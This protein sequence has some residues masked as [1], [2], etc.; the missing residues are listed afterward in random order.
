MSACACPACSQETSRVATRC[1]ACGAFLGSP[2]DLINLSTFAAAAAGLVAIVVAV[3]VIGPNFGLS[4]AIAA[5]R[6]GHADDVQAIQE[7]SEQGEISARAPDLGWDTDRF[8]DVYLISFTYV[9]AKAENPKRYAAW[10]VYEPAT[11][12]TTKIQKAEEFIDRYL[13]K[14]GLR[15]FVTEGLDDSLNAPRA[16]PTRTGTG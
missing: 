15:S 8:A 7:A 16:P 13:L 14:A 12:K 3:E 2:R 4:R 11:S 5:V 1:P 9:Q 10:W 6:R